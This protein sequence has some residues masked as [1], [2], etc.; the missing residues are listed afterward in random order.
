[1]KYLVTALGLVGVIATGCAGLGG[2]VGPTETQ[3]DSLT[4]KAYQ[5]IR[6]VKLA[7]STSS[8]R[9]SRGSI[10]FSMSR[11]WALR[12]GEA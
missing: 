1:M 10:R 9:V 12:N 6:Y 8:G 7:N 11:A 5:V 2:Y 3:H 4:G